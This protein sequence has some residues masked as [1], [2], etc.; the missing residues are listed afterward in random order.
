MSTPHPLIPLFH[1]ELSPRKRGDI[2]GAAQCEQGFNS[3]GQPEISRI[4]WEEL[5]A[6]ALIHRDYFVS[7]PIR[8]L[9]FEALVTRSWE[10]SHSH[11]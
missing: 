7:A 5:V 10:R 11:S 8:V 3:Q 2:P 4:V 9:V 1:K 6:N